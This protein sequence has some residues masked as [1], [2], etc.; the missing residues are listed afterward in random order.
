[1]ST[2]TIVI[3]NI[4]SLFAMICD[5]FASSRKTQKQILSV[6]TVSAGFYT[7]CSFVLKGYSAVVQD[8]AAI[9]RNI[10]AITKKDT[11]VIKITILL[12]G[13]GLGIYFNNLGLV[14]LLAVAANAEY[15]VA[16][17]MFKDNVLALKIA[18]LINLIMYCIFNAFILNF[19]GV[20]SNAFVAVTTTIFIFQHIKEK[21][22]NK[23]NQ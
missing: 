9:I 4:F 19:V 8:I 22:Q 12:L 5:S 23:N 10:F 2:W 15:T 1:M 7:L 16:V 3:G 20:V 11:K 18:F 6:Q 13:I 21:K 17:F 14:G